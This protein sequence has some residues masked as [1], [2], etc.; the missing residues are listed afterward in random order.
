MQ[1]LVVVCALALAAAKPVQAQSMD[2]LNL[3]FHGYATQGF[4]YTTRNNIFTTGSNSGSAAWTDAVVNVS[5]TPIPRLRVAVQTRYFLIGQIGNSITLDW[6]AAD[7]KFNEH[8]GVRFGKVKSP[9]GLFNEVQDIDP[10]YQWSLL[11]Q[12]VYPL[13]SRNSLLSHFGGVVYG[14]TRLGEK[15]GKLE[16]RGWA[17]QTVI[18]SDDGVFLYIKDRGVEQPNGVTSSTVGA[19]LR[20]NTPVHGLLLGASE[21][22]NGASASALL[23]GGVLPGEGTVQPFYNPYF[24]GK[25]DRARLMLAAEYSREPIEPTLRIASSPTVHTFVDRRTWYAMATYRISQNLS[26]GM[27]HSQYLDR[28]APL[29]PARFSKDWTLSARYDFSPFLYAKAEQHFIDGT[30]ITYS[31]AQNPNGL[32]PDTRLSILKIGVTF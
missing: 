2:D 30:A 13:L 28:R 16:Y 25:L 22:R 31:T 21:I 10:S 23:L 19:T 4:L 26:A 15:L 32:Q 6:A 20:W 29:G 11:P 9:L 14:S 18:G 12:G 3:Q 8:I 7:Y 5:V 27:Y 17:G 1:F 24:F